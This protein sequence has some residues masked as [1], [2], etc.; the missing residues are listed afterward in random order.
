MSGGRHGGCRTLLLAEQEIQQER[1]EH[2]VRAEHD[3]QR[4]NE[5]EV[6][7]IR[8]VRPGVR[9][10]RARQVDVHGQPPRAEREAGQQTALQREGGPQPAGDARTLPA[11]DDLREQSQVH[12]VPA[13]QRQE[14][15]QRQEVDAQVVATYRDRPAR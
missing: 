9:Q 13:Q 1:A 2:E 8:H 4:G 6:H 14:A 10:P 15:A 12:H 11:H 7:R 3:G 5:R